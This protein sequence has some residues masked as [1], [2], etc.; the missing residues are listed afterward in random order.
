MIAS[1]LSD[2][3][4]FGLGLLAGVVVAAHF[5]ICLRTSQADLVDAKARLEAA[6]TARDEA[7]AERDR[8]TSSI[9]GAE[10]Y[11]PRPIFPRPLGLR[12]R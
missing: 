7:V 3:W 2:C 4:L 5:Y 6:Q 12:H 9:D 10:T 11:Q 8:L 1:I